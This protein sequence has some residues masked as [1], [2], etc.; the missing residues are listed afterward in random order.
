M[1][2]G[3]QY[4]QSN[5]LMLEGAYPYTAKDGTCVYDKSKGFGKVS[6]YSEVPSGD[7]DQLRAALRDGPVSVA[8]EADDF[9][10]QS[11]TTGV[12]T[13]NCGDQLDH[14]VLAVGFGTEAG[15]EYFLVKNSWGAS[16]GDSGYVKIAPNMCGITKDAA[17]PY[18]S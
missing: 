6:T 16:W 14:G 8:I 1:V 17:I 4:A 11:Y 10:F 7:A 12:I 3:F 15:Q 2:Y 5:P 13:N 18:Y 9:S